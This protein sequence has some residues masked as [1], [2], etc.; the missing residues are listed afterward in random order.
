VPLAEEATGR[1]G[2]QAPWRPW[3]AP[4]PSWRYFP[5]GRPPGPPL[6]ASPFLHWTSH[7]GPSGS[8]SHP[9]RSVIEDTWRYGPMVAITAKIFSV[10]DPELGRTRVVHRGAVR[11]LPVVG[12][13]VVRSNRD[14]PYLVTELGI[15]TMTPTARETRMRGEG[16]RCRWWIAGVVMAYSSIRYLS[17]S[18][19]TGD[20]SKKREA[21]PTGSSA[22]RR[23]ASSAVR[24]QAPPAA[25]SGTPPSAADGIRRGAQPTGRA[26]PRTRSGDRARPGRR[27]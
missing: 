9:S 25:S 27:G 4:P 6:R 21:R 17:A 15:W 5:G 23:Q 2:T 1:T 24:R 13:V 12:A 8:C 26:E 18:R 3:A 19:P 11:S 20:N 16:A 14:R 7:N 22:V 10:P